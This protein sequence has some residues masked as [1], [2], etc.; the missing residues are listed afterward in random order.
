MTGLI[1]RCNTQGK[2][3]KMHQ[4]FITVVAI[5]VGMTLTVFAAPRDTCG[6]ET[7]KGERMAKELGLSAQQKSQLK[8]LRGEMR[9]FR[10]G[11]MDKMKALLDKSKEELLKSSPSREVLY[12][13]AR[14]MGEL[15]R[16]MAEKEAD[17]LLK[18]KA[19][20]TPDQFAKLLSMDFRQGKGHGPGNSPHDKGG[21][22]G[23]HPDMDD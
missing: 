19:V 21:H 2:E 11:Q 13:Y 20:L 9:D 7:G 4:K 8:E 14:E 3:I 10:K 18:A 17:H 12:G 5:V 1:V 22:G 16:A 23:R 6:A 15:R